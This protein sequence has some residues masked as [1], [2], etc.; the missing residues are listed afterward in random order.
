MTIEPSHSTFSGGN[1]EQFQ[2]ALIKVREEFRVLTAGKP[3]MDVADVIELREYIRKRTDLEKADENLTPEQK[4]WKLLFYSVDEE[5]SK[6]LGKDEK[7]KLDS[8]RLQIKQLDLISEN[9]NKLLLLGRQIEELLIRQHTYLGIHFEEN[10]RYR[11]NEEKMVADMLTETTPN[12]KR[13]EIAKEILQMVDKYKQ[14]ILKPL[15]DDQDKIYDLLSNFSA[16][17]KQ[18]PFT[19]ANDDERIKKIETLYKKWLLLTEELH[20]ERLKAI[21]AVKNL[22][23]LDLLIPN[24]IIKNNG[25]TKMN[26]PSE[27]FAQKAATADVLLKHAH[28]KE[29]EISKKRNPLSIESFGEPDSY[30]KVER[31]E[32]RSEPKEE[33]IKVNPLQGKAWFR[34]IKIIYIVACVLAGL[35]SIGLLSAGSDAGKII[36]L[37]IVVFFILIRKGFYY[38]MLGKTNWK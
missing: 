35:V 30:I 4:A 2:L 1:D 26:I 17:Y 10:N 13:I 19:V 22:L 15:F 24:H 18:T 32:A 11:Q 5:L 20:Q 14:I 23:E 8:L 7:I 25:D 36:V 28:A 27:E 16:I 6:T 21:T 34:F 37:G 29:E 38:V 33:N 3:N 31:E 9:V 12:S